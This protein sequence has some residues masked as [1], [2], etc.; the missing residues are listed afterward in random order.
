MNTVDFQFLIL[1]FLFVAADINDKVTNELQDLKE[2][3]AIRDW[4]SKVLG[5]G[6]INHDAESK[7]LKVYGYS[8]GYG[9]ADHQLTVDILKQVYPDY[10]I[11]FSDEGY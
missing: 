8:Q 6:R 11:S 3:K 5:G 9:K 1:F 2:S 7:T 10:N 4:R